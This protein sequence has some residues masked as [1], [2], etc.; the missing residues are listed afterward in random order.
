MPLNEH[1]TAFIQSFVEKAKR[2]RCLQLL[3]SA[4]QRRKLLDKWNHNPDIDYA[5]AAPIPFG[6][7]DAEKLL[8]LLR[9]EGAGESCYVIADGSEFDGNE[10]PIRAAVEHALGH[11]WFVLLSCVH[12]RLAFMKTEEIGS[13]HLLKRG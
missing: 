13:A 7:Y 11:D 1:E 2:D 10:L 4:K 8:D 12:G 6:H 9:R 5:F 3:S